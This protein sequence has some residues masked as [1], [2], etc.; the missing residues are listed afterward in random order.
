MIR[1]QNS[2]KE[3]KILDIT[4]FFVL[5]AFSV[6][7][8]WR[9]LRVGLDR[10]EGN[11]LFKASKLL[12]GQVLY[13]ELLH[14][15]P[16]ALFFTLVPLILTC[17]T[18]IV[19]FRSF[20]LLLN[21]VTAYFVFL[22]GRNMDRNREGL[23]A[24]LLFVYLSFHPRFLGFLI[25]AENF[26]NL[27]ASVVV[28]LLIAQ[29]I[30]HHRLFLVCGFLS[31]YATLIKQTG[32]F[33]FTIVI[34]F[35]ITLKVEQPH[36]LKMFSYFFLGNLLGLSPFVVYLTLNA[37]LQAAINQ[38]ILLRGTAVGEVASLASRLYKLKYMGSKLYGF[39]SI[40]LVH[41]VTLPKFDR[42]NQVIGFWFLS[43]VIFTQISPTTITHHF[44][45]IFP[46][47]A[48]FSGIG[49]IRVWESA[50]KL[51]S[52]RGRK[53]LK[54]KLNLKIFLLITLIFLLIIPLDIRQSEE[55]INF[56]KYEYQVRRK[57]NDGNAYDSTLTYDE[58]MSI[59][60]LLKQNAKSGEKIFVFMAEPQIY[61]LSGFDPVI[62]QTFWLEEDFLGLSAEEVEEIILRPLEMNHV[63]F[64]FLV[65]NFHLQNVYHTANGLLLRNHLTS[66]YEQVLYLGKVLV[67]IREK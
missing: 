19:R 59:T 32:V 41:I 14:P 37:A 38:V 35:L 67:Y 58:E 17:G 5:L 6:L 27:L 63:R 7:I 33:I 46:P 3:E 18:S 1:S 21:S 60:L 57:Q 16:P 48:I 28:Y 64:V 9:Y 4:I 51:F 44:L 42:K 12:V 40:F 15:K 30:S 53:I 11:W 34:L 55:G 52:F 36:R 22:I 54:E 39:F 20:V 62:P 66:H 45:I 25:L 8:G 65:N 47:L 23:V 24:G 2:S 31:I 61:Y 56:Y 13:R 50:Q 26:L 49:I 29:R 43:S 10:D